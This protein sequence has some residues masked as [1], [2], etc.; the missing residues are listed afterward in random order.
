MI[1]TGRICIKTAG[2]DSNR[3]CVVTEVIDDN[4]VNVMGETR[5]KKVNIKHLEPTNQKI[6]IKKGASKSD[7]SKELKKAGVG[8]RE[9]K[10]KRTAE[11]PKKKRKAREKPEE[12]AKARTKK[13]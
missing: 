2:R 10:P 12:G 1:E 4:F 6:T 11:R 5:S 7:I 9:T 13:T 8:T 3:K